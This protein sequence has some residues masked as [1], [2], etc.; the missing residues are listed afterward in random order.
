MPMTEKHGATS[1]AG[2]GVRLPEQIDVKNILYVTDFSRGAERAAPLVRRLAKTYEAHVTLLHVWSKTAA[3]VAQA[4]YMGNFADD[5]ESASRRELEACARSHFP[6]IESEFHTAG[7]EPCNCVRSAIQH[8]NIDLVVI[9]AERQSGVTRTLFGCTVEEMLHR[10]QV[11]VVTIGPKARKT[12]ASRAAK[13]LVPVTDWAAD[14]VPQVAR[15]MS[16]EFGTSMTLLRIGQGSSL[17]RM[18]VPTSE[19]AA[20]RLAVDASLVDFISD[21]REECKAIVEAA[22]ARD[23]DMIA[24]CVAAPH[25]LLK[26]LRSSLPYRVIM[27]AHCPVLTTASA[28]K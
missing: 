12:G 16:R 4:G 11:P 25:G 17:V 13:L 1:I 5:L 23:V 9:G 2:S 26:H 27:A 7:G 18:R 20:E 28:K 22:E 15:K 21:E 8:K 19:E 3:A 24:M 14:Q 6:E 10:I